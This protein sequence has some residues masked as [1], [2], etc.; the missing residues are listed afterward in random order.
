[1]IVNKINFYHYWLKKREKK[2]NTFGITQALTT[3]NAKQELLHLS[4]FYLRK[5]LLE[6]NLVICIS[7]M[8][9][10]ISVY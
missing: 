7:E 8:V 3:K 5:C 6:F 10:S 1:M 4:H 2:L 9:T